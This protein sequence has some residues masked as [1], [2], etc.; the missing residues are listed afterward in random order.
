MDGSGT[1]CGC[2]W[3]LCLF[4]YLHLNPS[5]RACMTPVLRGLCVPAAVEVGGALN[6]AMGG[7]GGEFV[8]VP[9]P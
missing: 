3:V 5:E 6:L 1:V 4:V 7:G 9:L 2:E 8:W